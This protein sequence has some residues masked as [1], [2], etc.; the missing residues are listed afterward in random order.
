MV[1]FVWWEVVTHWRAEWKSASTEHG[2]QYVT[3]DS[4]VKMPLSFA[5]NWKFLS[6]VSQQYSICEVVL[7]ICINTFIGATALAGAVFGQGTGPIF[8]EGLSCDSTA[9]SI[10]DCG[11]VLG[12]QFCSH[13]EDASVQCIGTIL[14][15][16]LIC[17]ARKPE[18]SQ[19][20]H[21]INKKFF[22]LRVEF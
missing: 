14:L 8:M 16:N 4:A 21:S 17:T 12:Y 22:L 7:T 15:E 9:S 2:A 18:I 20:P 19:H 6:Y 11:V 3:M 5:T 1:L 10:L 13:A